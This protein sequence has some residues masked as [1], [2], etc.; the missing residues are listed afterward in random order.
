MF[1]LGIYLRFFDSASHGR[2]RYASNQGYVGYSHDL[3][4]QWA[5]TFAFMQVRTCLY[6]RGDPSPCEATLEKNSH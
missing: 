5:D 3:Q 1:I 4:N 2:C 6:A